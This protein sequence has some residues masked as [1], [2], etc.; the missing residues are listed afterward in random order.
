MCQHNTLTI[1]FRPQPDGTPSV[2]GIAPATKPVD[3]S[4]VHEQVVT[5]WDVQGSVS[6]DGKQ[7]AIDYDRLIDQFGT[8]RV[9][10][11]LLARF[12][13]LTGHKP[14]PLLR[15]GMFFSHRSVPGMCF[16][17]RS[18]ILMLLS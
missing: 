13:K 4:V 17:Q 16:R 10:A 5:P 9:D 1:F 12:E 6:A 3:P 11:A 2:A 15:R 7:L 14:H 8:R 18:A